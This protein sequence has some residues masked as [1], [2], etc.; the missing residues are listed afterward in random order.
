MPGLDAI[1]GI[2]ILA[3]VAYHELSWQLPWPLHSGSAAAHIAKLLG[4]GF[5][6]V[7]LFFVLSG[8]LITGILL[9]ARSSPDYWRN[10]YIRRALRLLPALLLTLILLRLLYHAPY[11]YLGACLFYMANL[12]QELGIQSHFI[13]GVLW[14]LAVE[15]QFYLVW[16]FAIRF[17]SRRSIAMFAWASVL[18]SPLLRYLAISGI[19]SLGHN[20]DATWLISD[21]LAIGGL[22][23]LY[24]RSPGGTQIHR[25][26]RLTLGVGLAG[27]A[28]LLLAAPLGFLYRTTALGM[29]LQAEPFDLLFCA[30]L[31]LALQFGDRPAVLWCTRPLR[32]LGYISYGL[33]LYHLIVFREIDVLAVRFGLYRGPEL[34]GSLWLL[35]FLL[36]GGAAVGLS[37]L[38]RRFFE[39][40]FLSLKSRLTPSIRASPVAG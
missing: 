33:Y 32:F 2:A 18:L 38:S 11:A 36:A 10:F 1:R 30:L 34:S 9:D 22:L 37:Y 29:A 35:R 28:L 21:K 7:Q 24:L 19:L 16:P 5:L 20:A 39:N 31:L 26:R 8:F 27:L 3:V 13:Y 25:V 23:A 40:S 4:M 17:V 6:G 12:T 14:S 15:E